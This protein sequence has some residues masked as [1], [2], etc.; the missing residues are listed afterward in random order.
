MRTISIL[1]SVS[2]C[3]AITSFGQSVQSDFRIDRDSFGRTGIAVKSRNLPALVS[4]SGATSDDT[5]LEA[6]TT[7]SRF[8]A[9]VKIEHFEPGSACSVRLVDSSGVAVW[10]RPVTDQG[11]SWWTAPASGRRATLHLTCTSAA[12]VARA[13]VSQ[14]MA[15]SAGATQEAFTPPPNLQSIVDAT[16][17]T[18]DAARAVVRLDIVEDNGR[19]SFPC[20]GFLIAPQL[21]ITN[22]H[23]ISTRR[24]L[25]NATAFF[26]DSA[27]AL[28]FDGSSEPNKVLDYV[29][30]HLAKP[31]T[32]RAPLLLSRAGLATNEFVVIQYP[33]GGPQL[34]SRIDCVAGGLVPASSDEFFHGCDTKGGSSG[35]PV[36][37]D[38]TRQVIGLHHFGF[39][40]GSKVAQNRAVLIGPILD[41]LKQ[42]RLD[43][44]DQIVVVP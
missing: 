11:E 41:D 18:R 15:G 26:E 8:R 25:F 37:V 27:E 13:T 4:V 16:T 7:S 3:W 22:Q 33:D 20:T 44:F 38:E 6:P 9:F 31:V 29:V 21:V 34:F 36:M 24:E 30:C 17:T 32:D 35:A 10:E 19:H 5:L 39:P 14:L 12:S 28:S 43:Y 42:N 1:L 40:P 23:C 2:I